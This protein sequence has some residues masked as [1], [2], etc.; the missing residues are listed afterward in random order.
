MSSPP[1]TY[2]IKEVAALTGLP[3]STLRYYES[4][5]LTPPIARGE[6]SGHRVYSEADLDALVATACLSATGMPLEQMREYVA[7]GRAGAESAD[8]QIR[9]LRGQ[10]T[11]LRHEERRLAATRRY[12]AI[13]VAFW[14][15]MRDD[16]QALALDLARQAE[17]LADELR[18]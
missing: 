10:D 13:K 6:S 8:A 12:L 18:T 9:L 4:I 11:H 3:A 17:A 14:E 7:N 15:A 1:R 16:D 5:G 2:T